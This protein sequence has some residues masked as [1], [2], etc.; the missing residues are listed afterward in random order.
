MDL[1]DGKLPP[2]WL[3]ILTRQWATGGN[4][5]NLGITD[6]VIYVYCLILH[7]L[8][9]PDPVPYSPPLTTHSPHP[10]WVQGSFKCIVRQCQ[11]A[12]GLLAPPWHRLIAYGWGSGSLVFLQASEVGATQEWWESLRIST[13]ND[14][15]QT[16][17]EEMLG[18]PIVPNF[19]SGGVPGVLSCRRQGHYCFN[20][21]SLPVVYG[22]L[23]PTA[24]LMGNCFS[25]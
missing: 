17:R 18:S 7:F 14:N 19:I 23:S 2:F 21:P 22:F 1:T 10:L 3:W 13:R 12:W 5:M 16:G 6:S 15:N 11:W 25:S 9:S 8:L 24:N 20:E 4:M